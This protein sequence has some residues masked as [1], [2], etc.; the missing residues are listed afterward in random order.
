MGAKKETVK[1]AVKTGE[2]LG[3]FQ[4]L[5]KGFLKLKSPKEAKE[6]A[7]KAYKETKD[8]I[9]DKKVKES[10]KTIKSI[11]KKA[12]IGTGVG[13]GADVLGYWG[14]GESP[15]LGP[16]L[17]KGKKIIGMKAKGGSVRRM[18]KGGSVSRGTGAAIKGTKFKGV[19]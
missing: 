19:F 10:A 7:K 14:T 13:V 9:I 15:V 4:K 3:L 5:Y 2:K 11:K 1:A 16:A 6:A 18:N 17:E 12:I 8:A